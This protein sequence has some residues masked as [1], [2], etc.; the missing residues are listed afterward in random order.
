MFPGS[1]AGKARWELGILGPKDISSLTPHKHVVSYSITQ[2]EIV[3]VITFDSHLDRVGD[4][5]DGPWVSECPKAELL[6]CYS[7]WEPEVQTLLEVI[8]SVWCFA[9]R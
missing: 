3:N 5:F 8:S 2:G 7:G 1:I 9:F 4:P 6:Q